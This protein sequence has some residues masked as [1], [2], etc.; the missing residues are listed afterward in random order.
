[1]TATPDSPEHAIPA[2]MA[3]VMPRVIWLLTKPRS[4]ALLLAISLGLGLLDALS[5]LPLSLL[6]GNGPFWDYPSGIMGGATDM[7]QVLVGYLYLVQSP[8]SVPLLHVPNLGGPLGTNVF[9]LDVVP[10]VALSGKL[11]HSE[12]GI[13]V[14]PYGIWLL[15]CLV[16]P[17][18]AMTTLLAVVG[19]RSLIAAVAGTLLTLSTPYL[20]FRW[21]HIASFAQFWIIFAL[22]LYAAAVRHPRDWRP[23]AGWCVVLMGAFGTNMYLFSM[24]GLCWV[25]SLGQR[26]LAGTTSVR[27]LLPEAAG[28]AGAITCGGLL[29]GILSPDLA[30]AGDSTFGIFSMNLAS[31]LVPQLSGLIPGLRSY[32]IGMG[33]QYEGFAYLGL[34]V[35]LLLVVNLP[36]FL[37]WMRRRFLRHILLICA[38]GLCVAFALSNKV[39]IGSYLLLDVPLPTGVARS[40]G[41]FRS[42]GR[43]FWPVGYALTAAGIILTLRRH[44][45]AI[46]V[47]LLGIATVLQVADV[48]PIRRMLS[49]SADHAGAAIFDRTAAAALVARSQAVEIFPSFGCSGALW[50]SGSIRRDEWHR[51]TQA[52]MEFQLLAARD[53]LPIN[54]VYNARLKT[55]CAAEGFAQRRALRNGTLYV[56][57][58]GFEPVPEQLG[59]GTLTDA[60][61]TVD[62]FRYCLR[63]LAASGRR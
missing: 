40:L 52:N 34:G 31:P 60:C 51:L 36:G 25:A 16:L 17:G 21:G 48:G 35:L 26:W 7:V 53:D 11:I 39:H 49:E 14:N 30:S 27:R 42:S 23:A 15:A 62:W 33:S 20:L 43:F 32:H 1:M 41:V 12:S 9:W 6:L 46:G 24:A 59:G 63:P 54:S 55:D 57:L 61:S 28:I 29:T 3:N 18:V 22:A 47:G 2:E 56:Y 50:Q 4:V 45:R 19:E 58:T 10:W 13:I 5:M 37:A 38:M 8:W 44:G